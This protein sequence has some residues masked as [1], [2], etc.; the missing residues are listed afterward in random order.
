MRLLDLT[1]E[2]RATIL[3][4]RTAFLSYRAENTRKTSELRGELGRLLTADAPDRAAVDDV[5]RRIGEQQAALQRRVVEQAL[6]V[7]AVLTPEQRPAFEALMQRHLRAGVPMQQ[8][9]PDDLHEDQ[10]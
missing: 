4:L 9:A 1:S 7:R 5:L 8:P 3:D 2:Q 10:P 6:A